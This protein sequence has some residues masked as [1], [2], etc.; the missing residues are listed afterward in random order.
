MK[1]AVLKLI[2][3]YMRKISP[4]FPA[5][6]RYYPTC[7]DYMFQAVEKYGVIRGGWLGV[8]R[9]SRCNILFPG[10]VDPLPELKT[11]NRKNKRR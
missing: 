10:E 5:R 6:C 11:G 1:K 2:R 7:S 3:F 8:K 9:L 4:L